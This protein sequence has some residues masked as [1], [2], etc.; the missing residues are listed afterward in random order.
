M[1]LLRLLLAF[2]ALA[3]AASAQQVTLSLPLS[4][5]WD[6]S[7]RVSA[8]LRAGFQELFLLPPVAKEG[9]KVEV[10]KKCQCPLTNFY[11]S[12][13][14]SSKNPIRQADPVR[15][16]ILPG[17]VLAPELALESESSSSQAAGSW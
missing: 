5:L 7:A 1:L 11:L 15:Q 12:L 10:F 9:H 8:F 16:L 13:I 2:L 3:A 4:L 17:A 6:V 14:S